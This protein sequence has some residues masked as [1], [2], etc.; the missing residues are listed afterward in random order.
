MFC[1]IR[2]SCYSRLIKFLSIYKSKKILG[3]TVTIDYPIEAPRALLKPS[4]MLQ[5]YRV[6]LYLK[7]VQRK[8]EFLKKTL[9]LQLT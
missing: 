7:E 3:K 5:F 4:V 1:D 8:T 2:I 6:N 9:L